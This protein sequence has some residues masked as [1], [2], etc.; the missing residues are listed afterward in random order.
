MFT[1]LL[2]PC[3]HITP[4]PPR[5]LPRPL[6]DSRLAYLP[7]QSEVIRGVKLW[8]CLV[9]VGAVWRPLVL[10][11]LDH[12]GFPGPVTS[13]RRTCHQPVTSKHHF[14]PMF[15]GHLSPCRHLTPPSRGSP[16]PDSSF[17]G[18]PR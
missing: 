14:R 16:P 8:S 15:T 7:N 1:G 17:P 6:L 11:Y 13:R 12:H 2:T 4:P 3:C 9:L 18:I 5:Y 10:K